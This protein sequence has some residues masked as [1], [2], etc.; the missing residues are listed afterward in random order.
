[1]QIL[2]RSHHTQTLEDSPHV[3]FAVQ[4]ICLLLSDL[5]PALPLLCSVCVCLC[6]CVLRGVLTPEN[7]IFQAFLPLDSSWV[8]P[9]RVT[10]ERWEDEGRSQVFLLLLCLGGL[11]SVPLWSRLPLADLFMI[12]V[13]ARWQGSRQH[14]LFA[15][16][17]QL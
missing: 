9:I 16:S 2:A 13:P 6:V 12:P 10:S 7:Y 11:P 15:L 3:L 14:H 8:W 1:M 5:S 4:V 17:L